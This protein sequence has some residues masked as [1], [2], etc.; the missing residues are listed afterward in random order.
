[1]KTK[2]LLGA[3]LGMCALAWA[4]KDPVIMTVNGVDVPK[5]EFEYLYHKNSQQQLTAQPLDDYV[6]MFVNYRLKVADAIADGV[7]TTASFRQEMAQYRH[8]LAAPYMADSVLL[9][10]LVKEAWQRSA[11]ELQVSHIMLF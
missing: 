4:A 8:E 3:G 1:M 2:L 10:N 9:N 11:D 6:E 7:D 5:S